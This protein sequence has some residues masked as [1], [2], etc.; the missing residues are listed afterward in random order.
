MPWAIYRLREV[1]LNLF[2]LMEPLVGFKAPHVRLRE[3]SD[4]A[5]S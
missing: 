3:P 2:G 4:N 1:V 5:S